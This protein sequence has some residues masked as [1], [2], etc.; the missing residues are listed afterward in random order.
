M[1]AP[2]L[3][4]VSCIAIALGVVL[5]FAARHGG[6]EAG[7]SG[8]NAVNPGGRELPGDIH[9]YSGQISGGRSSAWESGHG[10]Q[11]DAGE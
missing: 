5:F 9:G 1:F 11:G 4:A 2:W 6:A 8:G 10:G 3:A 7:G